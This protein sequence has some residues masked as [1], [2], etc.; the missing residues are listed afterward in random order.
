HNTLIRM[1]LS[2]DGRNLSIHV[3]KKDSFISTLQRIC[4]KEQANY[5]LASLLLLSEGV[6]V[7]INATQ[8]K[9]TLWKT[10]NAESQYKKA[11][12]KDKKTSISEYMFFEADAKLHMSVPQKDFAK[13]VDFFKKYN[14][15]KELPDTSEDFIT[16]KFL[17]TP[18]FLIQA[19]VFEYIESQEDAVQFLECV[20][21]LL[22]SLG[23]VKELSAGKKDVYNQC[24]CA[25]EEKEKAEEYLQ[26]FSDVY[27]M[28]KKFD[29]FPFYTKSMLPRHM[30]VR[31]YNKGQDEFTNDIF[32]NCVEAGLYA[33]FCCLAYDAKDKKYDVLRMLGNRQDRPETKPLRD[34]FGLKDVAPNN[35]ATVEMFE[36]WNK[37]M[38]GLNCDQITYKSE[39]KNQ[40]R[41]C[42]LNV[43][44]V[45]AEV[46]GRLDT[47]QEKIDGFVQRLNSEEDP[48]KNIY[49]E[50]KKYFANL[51]KELSVN[52]N[53]EVSVSEMAQCVQMDVGD[54]ISASICLTYKHQK[55]GLTQGLVASIMPGHVNLSL[56]ENSIR[57]PRQQILEAF[58][59]EKYKD[60]VG[61]ASC[62]FFECIENLLLKHTNAGKSDSIRKIGFV[63][64]SLVLSESLEKATQLFMGNCISMAWK[65]IIFIHSFFMHTKGNALDIGPTHPGLR[66]AL[67][68]L[69]NVLLEEEPSAMDMFL[70]VPV[71]L[72][73]ISS[74]A[75]RITL[76]NGIISKLFKMPEVIAFLHLYAPSGSKNDL[77]A[78]MTYF[79]E[80][81]EKAKEPLYKC[82]VLLLHKFIANIAAT[83]FS[84]DVIA[85]ANEIDTILLDVSM[86]EKKEAERARN[87]V[88]IFWFT[89][90][91]QC[92]CISDLIS[93][94]CDRISPEIDTSKEY[95]KYARCMYLPHERRP[96]V[97]HLRAYARTHKERKDIQKIWKMHKLL[98]TVLKVY[99]ESKV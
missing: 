70:R 36:E 49:S 11:V 79:R 94:L 81:K 39:H 12:R 56:L 54:S 64:K 21:T 69:G 63:A 34:F 51:L 83:V 6:A 87:L 33:L 27:R 77:N 88:A 35:Y 78:I 28:Q 95:V 97:E 15:P 89:Y 14:K 52:K 7:P 65:K 3:A 23:C 43:L 13:V 1:F 41:S 42:F 93:E 29:W 37:V 59:A 80:Y 19:Y 71:Q 99:G 96:T 50:M 45:I 16:G 73:Q 55:T 4:T 2:V 72:N 68:I 86:K 48:E 92:S 76:E 22:E 91:M 31:S 44:Y 67:N 66:L 85:I 74:L 18:Q 47:E 9:V 82:D 25:T 62:L 5:V 10:I 20:H 61:F 98:S 53:M 40:I 30:P 8:T 17:N 46:T 57:L 32:S 58:N 24:F 38:S 60:K 26:P 90:A 84:G 75:P